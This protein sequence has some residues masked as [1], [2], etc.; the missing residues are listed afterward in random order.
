MADQHAVISR[1]KGA[2]DLA[3]E[4]SSGCGVEPTIW[5]RREAKSITNS[6]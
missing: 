1:G 5:T 2:T 3:H 4:Q 6:V